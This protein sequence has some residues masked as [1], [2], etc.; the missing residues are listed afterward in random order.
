MEPKLLVQMPTSIQIQTALTQ[1]AEESEAPLRAGGCHP[2]GPETFEGSCRCG[3]L[4][5]KR[6]NGSSDQLLRDLLLEKCGRS[7]DSPAG[8]GT[9]TGAAWCLGS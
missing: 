3:A 2:R 1:D 9:R 7:W 5:A 8:F 6:P 4:G